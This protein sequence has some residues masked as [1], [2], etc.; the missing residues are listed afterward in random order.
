[1]LRNEWRS[2]GCAKE[3]R[4][5]VLWRQWTAFFLAGALGCPDLPFEAASFEWADIAGAAP[6][7]LAADDLAD[8]FFG[9]SLFGAAFLSRAFFGSFFDEKMPVMLSMMDIGWPSVET[10]QQFRPPRNCS[11]VDS[12]APNGTEATRWVLVDWQPAIARASADLI[13]IDQIHCIPFGFGLADSWQF[14]TQIKVASILKH[15]ANY[16]SI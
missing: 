3:S 16:L 13:P 11:I 4:F 10:D 9:A 12:V 5:G 14:V 6:V 15:F 1:M 8:A 2:Q 7:F